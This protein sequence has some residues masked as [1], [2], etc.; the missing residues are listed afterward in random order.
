MPR[1]SKDLQNMKKIFDE[2]ENEINLIEEF[3]ETDFLI[4]FINKVQN[5]ASYISDYRHLGYVKHALEDI[6]AIVILALISNCNTFTEIELFIK[7]HIKWLQKHLNILT[8][9]PSKNCIMKTIAYIE[10]K[11][12]ESICRASLLIFLKNDKPIYEDNDLIIQDIKSMDGKTA[13]SSDRSNSINGPVSKVNAMSVYS[14]K[15]DE[16]EATEFINEKTNEIPTGPILLERI[17]IKDCIVT[18]DALNTQTETISYIRSKKAHYVA[19]IKGNQKLLLEYIEEY[20]NDKTLLKEAKKTS[21]LKITELG[22]YGSEKREYVF[23]NDIEH[24]E[25]K[26]LW[27][28]IKSIGFAKRTYTTKEGKTKTDTRYYISSIDSSKIQLLSKTIRSEWGVE[29]KLHY[30]LDMVFKEDNN[31]CF[32]E[33]SQKNLNIIRKFTLKVLKI[34]KEKS[35][36]SMNSIRFKVNMDFEN[37]I[38]D[39]INAIKLANLDELMK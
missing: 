6:I 2:E 18:F 25:K 26:E 30:Y 31:K 5:N 34:Y 3:K 35:K 37:E 27:S 7:R 32:V 14:V 24:L 1:I 36:L 9:L 20:F 15:N 10:P 22:Q 8:E 29:N 23:T 17:N 28:D 4:E 12:L 13:N 21:H 16:C 39:I 19:P 11:E 38:I 33:N